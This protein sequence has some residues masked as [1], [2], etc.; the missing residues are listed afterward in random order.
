MKETASYVMPDI[1]A[2]KLIRHQVVNAGRAYCY[3][4]HDEDGARCT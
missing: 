3:E 4:M 2:T 1:Y